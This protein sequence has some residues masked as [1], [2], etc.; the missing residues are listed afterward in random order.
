MGSYVQYA[1]DSIVGLG[2]GTKHFVERWKY[3]NMLSGQ[4]QVIAAK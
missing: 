1:I 4:S 2:K 3:C